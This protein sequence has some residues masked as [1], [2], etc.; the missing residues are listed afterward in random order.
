MKDPVSIDQLKQMVGRDLEPTPWIEITQEQINAFADT[1]FDHQYIHVDPEA[2]KQSPFG[3]TI[4]HGFL[5]LSLMS[6]MYE[7]FGFILENVVFALNY[8][9]DKIRFLSPVKV[10]SRIRARATVAE[11]L[12]KEGGQ[13]M[14]KYDVVVEIEGEEKPALIA[15]WLGLQAVSQ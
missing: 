5:T 7:S 2:A 8:G 1:T 11:I 10:N 6:H 4:A 15:E 14:I 3:G 12:E 9:F 13:V